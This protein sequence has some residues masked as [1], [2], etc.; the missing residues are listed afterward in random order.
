LPEPLIESIAYHQD[1]SLA[2][3]SPKLVAQVHLGNILCISFG[4][5]V[6][7]DGLAY[8]FHPTPC[9]RRAWK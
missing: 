1:P 7:T 5:G 8:T 2:Q 9:G 4:I 6:G 3:S